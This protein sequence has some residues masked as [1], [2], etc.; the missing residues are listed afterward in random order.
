LGGHLDDNGVSSTLTVHGDLVNRST[1]A[2]QFQFAHSTL[3]M[4]SPG[5]AGMP[6]QIT[7][8][9]A[10]RG[11]VLAGLDLNM[12]V[13]S[14]VFGDGLG[15]PG[16]DFFLISG[17]TTLYAYGLSIR[18]DATLDLGGRTLYYLRDGVE[19]NGILGTGLLL[20][21]SYKN[22]SLIEII[23]EPSVPVLFAVL[24]GCAMLS[25]RRTTIHAC[26]HAADFPAARSS[27]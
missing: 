1:A 26:G 10:D 27:S 25:R 9:A 5:L 22:G 3:A 7:W 14:V 19:Y 16:G 24:L 12:A 17:A 23:P 20:E 13:G 11:A 8:E 2:D 21:G 15:M 4:L 6:H 18:E